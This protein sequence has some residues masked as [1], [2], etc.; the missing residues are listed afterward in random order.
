MMIS[1]KN[2]TAFSFH[3]A[4]GFEPSTVRFKVCRLAKQTTRPPTVLGAH[5]YLLKN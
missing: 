4:Q 1:I 3:A 5:I 2:K